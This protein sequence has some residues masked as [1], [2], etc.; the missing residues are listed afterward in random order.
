MY[1]S[2]NLSKWFVIV[3]LLV[4]C[5]VLAKPA[6]ARSTDQ[7]D[8]VI[9]YVKAGGNGDCS[10]WAQACEL[11]TAIYIAVPGDQIWVAAGTYKPTTSSNRSAT[12]QIK[13]GVAIYGGFPAEGGDET[14][15]DWQLN[16]T[17]LSGDIG[18]PGNI[19][20]NC[21]HVV[22]AISVD[23]TGSL[24][25]FYVVN[26][27]ANSSNGLDNV[28]GGIYLSNAAPTLTHVTFSDNTASYRGG[29]MYN[30]D[31]SPSLINV[32]FSAN[33]AEY[34][35]GMYNY[36]YSSAMLTNVTFVA[37]TATY[38]G[39]GMYNYYYSSATLT[40]VTFVANTATYSGGGMYNNDSSPSLTN[41][42]FSANTAESGGGM[43]N[44]YYSSAMLTNVTFSEN[45][46]TYDGGGMYN[47]YYSSATL[48]NV[49][50]SENT[51]TYD[52]GGMYNYYYSSA[53]LTNVTFSANTAESGGGIYIVYNS[54]ATLTNLTFVANTATY[55]GGGMFNYDSSPS[56]TNVTF[57][58]NTAEY[59]GGMSNYGSSATLTNATFSANMA[60]YGGGM[61]NYG[62][63]TLTNATF[64]ANT[65]ESGGG[66]YNYDSS[67]T[68]TNVTFSENTATYVGGG[69]SSYF[70]SSATLTNVTFSTNTADSGGGIYGVGSNVTLTNAILWDNSPDQIVGEAFEV[71]YSDI[72][73]GYPGEGNINSAPLLGS[74]EDNGG[75]TLTHA[76]ME[77]SP[78]IDAGD[79]SV[80]PLTDQR[81][82]VRPVD[83]NS[84][85]IEGCDM[86]AYEYGSYPATYNVNISIFGNGS[87]IKEPEKDF[88]DFGEVVTLTANA[89]PGW[90][91]GGWG[92]D[93]SGLENPI[94]LTVTNDLSISA[95]FTQDEYTLS[96]S[97]NPPEQGT[98]TI[99]PIKPFYHYGDVV[100]LTAT[101]APGWSFANWTGD[102]TGTSNPVSVTITGDTSITANFTQNE[103]ALTVTV[104]PENSG[105]VSLD[106]DQDTYHYGD[107]VTL[108]ATP[109]LGWSFANWTGD[110]TGTANPV[111]VTI[112]KNTSVT[113]H[114]TQN[115]YTLTV[116]VDPENS[117]TVSLDPQQ[118][119]YHY[120]DVVTL[121]ATPAPGWSFSNWTGDATG[122]TNP[123]EVTITKNTSVTAHFTQDEYT[124][125]VIISP[126]NGGSVTIEPAQQTYH[127]SEQVTLS[128][129]AN[130]YWSFIGWDG[131]ASGTDNPLTITILGNTEI[132]ANFQK[133]WLYLPL[134]SR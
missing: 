77:G 98:V 21:Y 28:G 86:G 70:Y 122:T 46:A 23:V 125:T 69:M 95:T 7:T 102:A 25:G 78:A 113:A 58:A 74:L 20:D 115:E 54:S 27:N 40:N 81:F 43:S 72:Q 16:K 59:G 10:S 97:I 82:F 83:G 42:T 120:G 75:F 12:F 105:T 24:D 31:S 89:D 50:F 35:G 128:A 19:N 41:V 66:M 117:G 123:V 5:V 22:T 57:S 133:F 15:R 71:T 3:L 68:L 64:S 134:I 104:D 84:D 18:L 29:G 55:S 56:L 13:S 99:T 34:G 121:T 37:N 87:V 14:S 118:A 51:A 45:T 111:S 61:Y 47:Y 48:T 96:V 127:Y 52:G 103:Y 6:F 114:F 100:T 132:I 38:S 130:P 79:I 9:R 107:V 101:P 8:S 26:G 39:G 92:G 73:G 129:M 110:A 94:S 11:Q 2:K 131:D 112:T 17:Y 90:S 119:T 33:T 93:A 76:L 85:G 62:S 30:Y 124:L 53:T 88:Y 4:S 109:E 126:E 106:P 1:T 67:A 63:A 36:Y 108:T 32:T 65:A 49:T 60:E 91:F 44:C 116:T 80:C